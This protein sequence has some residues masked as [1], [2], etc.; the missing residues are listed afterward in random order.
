MSKNK[1][2]E[3]NMKLVPFTANKY[4]KAFININKEFKEDLFQEGYIYLLKAAN[5]YDERKGKF[6][7]I[8]IKC[9]YGGMYNYINRYFNKHYNN[10]YMSLESKVYNDNTI[11]LEELIG[12]EENFSEVSDYYVSK[13]KKVKIK[14]I[15]KIVELAFLGYSQSEIGRIL[16]ISQ[17]AVSSKI[18]RA[19]V[20]ISLQE[21][22]DCII[23]NLRNI[24]HSRYLQGDPY[25]VI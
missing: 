19:R 23:C 3:E 21:R 12:Y 22:L 17:E 5:T 15:D 11:K 24:N 14:N 4:F 10:G 8:A 9:I 2:F 25:G 6:S 7:T 16:G 1:L 13:I 18:K 20:E